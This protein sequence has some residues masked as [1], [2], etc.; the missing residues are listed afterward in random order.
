MKD[1]GADKG[2]QRVAEHAERPE[3]DHRHPRQDG[4]LDRQVGEGHWTLTPS[5]SSPLG[6]AATAG[7][8]GSCAGSADHITYGPYVELPAGSYV[9]TWKLLTDDRDRSSLDI[10]QLDITKNSGSTYLGNR[11]VNRS[12]FPDAQV[13]TEFSISATHDGTGQLEFRTQ[14]IDSHRPCVSVDWVRVTR[15]G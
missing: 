6:L 4:A 13:W 1:R 15:T 9:V 7:V 3:R 11:R 12:E 2:A 14:Y 8:S 5:A 10:L